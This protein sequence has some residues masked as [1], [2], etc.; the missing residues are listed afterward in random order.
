MYDSLFM[1][2]LIV[3][4]I[5]PFLS[6]TQT[7][8]DNHYE[9][10]KPT[11]I[12]IKSFYGSP[13]YAKAIDIACD[14]VRIN[15]SSKAI[16]WYET[17]T[18]FEPLHKVDLYQ[19]AQ[20]LIKNELYQKALMN[21]RIYLKDFGPNDVVSNYINTLENLE[22]LKSRPSKFKT[23][24]SPIS[25][26]GIPE[27]SPTKYKDGFVYLK[28]YH[29]LL[30]AHVEGRSSGH[31]G[32]FDLVYFSLKDSSTSFLNHVVNS[33]YHEG[34]SCFSNHDSTI[35]FSRNNYY[36]HHLHTNRK[37]HIEFQIFKST[38]VDQK[39]Q[40]EELLEVNIPGA[41]CTEPWV[42]ENQ[43]LMFFS[44]NGIDGFGGY[45][46]YYATADGEGVFK[47]SKNLGELIS[48]SG[49]EAHPWFDEQ[50]RLLYFSSDG[51]GGLGGM[52]LFVAVLDEDFNVQNVQNLGPTINSSSNDLTFLVN[53][54]GTGW[55]TS[56]RGGDVDIYDVTRDKS[57]LVHKGKIVDAETLRSVA[58]ARILVNAGGVDMEYLLSD[59]N[60]DYEVRGDTTLKYVITVEHKGHITKKEVLSTIDRS[61]RLKNVTYLFRRP[62]NLMIQLKPDQEIDFSSLTI[63]LN[64]KS[65]YDLDTLRSNQLGEVRYG[66]SANS[67][68]EL[69]IY[70]KEN[71]HILDKFFTLDT[72]EDIIL[73]INLDKI[74]LDQPIIIKGLSINGEM[75]EQNPALDYW[76]NYLNEYPDYLVEIGVHSSTKGDRIFNFKQSQDFAQEICAYLWRH[77]IARYRVKSVGYGEEIPLN[78]CIEGVPCSDRQKDDNQRVEIRI[79]GFDD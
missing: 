23:S 39:W 41:S 5:F 12:N 70:D 28:P 53:E 56:D 42:S 31:L 76:V 26:K 3:F 64:N 72:L 15:E 63:L 48:T 65:V 33:K 22:E 67:H 71:Y 46:I 7:D 18:D 74:K 47:S 66:L 6:F 9:Y 11:H 16:E 43:K 58:G 54:L 52:D 55:M 77:G 35:Y 62:N 2:L 38:L 34:P 4:L 60:G 8:G 45:D 27:L 69:L 1:R 44:A 24:L 21:L 30:G 40:K 57:A 79:I 25:Q 10:L 14:Y 59:K 13:S 78:N 32:F 51:L 20:Q 75:P 61:A 17:A 19:Y 37:K 73:E 68:Y 49:N 50:K 29:H 36:N